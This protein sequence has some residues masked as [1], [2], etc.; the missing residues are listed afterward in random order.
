MLATGEVERL[1][2]GLSVLVSK[3]SEGRPVAALATFRAL[4]LLLDPDLPRRALEPDTTPSLAW[5]GREGFSASLAELRELAVELDGLSLYA[6][7][8]SV[9]T[10]GLSA[11]EVAAGLGAE[12]LSTPRFLREAGGAGLMFV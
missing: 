6:C 2:S 9:E 8:A 7:S 10:M 5:A 3:A 11:E 12:V 1:Y 4:A